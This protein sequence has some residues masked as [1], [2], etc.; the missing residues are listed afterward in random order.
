MKKLSV[1]K[2][3]V[4]AIIT[5]YGCKKNDDGGT[6]PETPAYLPL[7]T[8]V[9]G[10][11]G[12]QQEAVPYDSLSYNPDNTP[13]EL[14]LEYNAYSHTWHDRIQFF[15]N[16]R[17]QCTSAR[18]YGLGDFYELDSLVYGANKITVF[19][20]RADD[21]ELTDSTVISF[22]SDN[23]VALLGSKDTVYEDNNGKQLSY[24][25]FT[26]SGGNPVKVHKHKYNNYFGSDDVTIE[27]YTFTYDD[28]PNAFLN[29]FSQNPYLMVIMQE[30]AGGIVSL[31]KNNLTSFTR[32]DEDGD[33]A[34]LNY[35]NAY[36]ADGKLVTQ[37]ATEDQHTYTIQHNYI[38]AK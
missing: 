20:L 33:E 19:D 32:K 15:Y 16:D 13:A 22:N 36:D 5:F 23:Q 31:G 27:E 2:L 6:K 24:T 18:W 4:L 34:G 12:N 29:L 9:T 26:Y 7:S 28:H 14:F 37:K 17:K 30:N 3:L 25:E 21:H 8:V 1:S 35:T 11:D 10:E 38:K